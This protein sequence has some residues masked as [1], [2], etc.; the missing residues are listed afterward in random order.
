MRTR[1]RG[2]FHLFSLSLVDLRDSDND[3]EIPLDHCRCSARDCSP[4]NA[5]VMN[6]ESSMLMNGDRNRRMNASCQLI[7]IVNL[8]IPRETRK[9]L[10]IEREEYL[11]NLYL[12]SLM[13]LQKTFPL[14]RCLSCW[15]PN[16]T[17]KAKRQQRANEGCYGVVL[18]LFSLSLYLPQPLLSS[19][20]FCFLASLP[21]KRHSDKDQR[22]NRSVSLSPSLA[23]IFSS[24]PT[25]NRNN[26][27]GERERKKT[28]PVLS[29][30]RSGVPKI[31]AKGCLF[32]GISAENDY[33]NRLAARFVSWSC[34]MTS[35]SFSLENSSES[36]VDEE[37]KREIRPTEPTLPSLFAVCH[38]GLFLSFSDVAEEVGVSS[39]AKVFISLCP[40]VATH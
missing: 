25:A 14:S 8:R 21:N 19:K 30:S 39:S 13:A 27:T 40:I 35:R 28:M 2:S 32:A 38:Q 34:H 4:T 6:N 18:R 3:R 12:H 31:R 9:F 10:S 1:R 7:Q 37:E 26:S 5:K 16:T 11:I 15:I 22:R 29:L 20:T 23:V 24:T 36:G 33:G 17:N